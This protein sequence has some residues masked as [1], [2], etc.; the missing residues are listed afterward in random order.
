MAADHNLGNALAVCG[1]CFSV[2]RKKGK[3]EKWKWLAKRLVN[4]PLSKKSSS[5]FSG[6]PFS[7]SYTELHSVIDCQENNVASEDAPQLRP[8]G[9]TAA[10]RTPPDDAAGGRFGDIVLLTLNERLICRSPK[11]VVTPENRD[12]IVFLAVVG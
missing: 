10:F 3:G 1:N 11:S 6:F 12:W 9:E 8:Q 7:P 5:H 2:R 4:I